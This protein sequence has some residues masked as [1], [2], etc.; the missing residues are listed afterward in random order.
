MIKYSL[1]IMTTCIATTIETMESWEKARSE[2]HQAPV[3]TSCQFVALGLNKK[4][5]LL[6]E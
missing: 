4:V 2:F 5:R 1:T 3:L 6:Q